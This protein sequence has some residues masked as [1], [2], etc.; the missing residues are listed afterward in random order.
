ME[1]SSVITGPVSH[2]HSVDVQQILAELDVV[3]AQGLSTQ[4]AE[5]RLRLFGPNIL[6]E[7]NAV[8]P[9]TILLRQF[10]SVMLLILFV[11]AV[12]SWFLG[13]PFDATVIVILILVNIAI[14][15][16]QEYTAE[17]AISSLKKLVETKCK[18][19]RD[20]Q[21]TL[22]KPSELVP[23]DI[24]LL[25]GGDKVSAD[26]RLVV[27][28]NLQT[29]E[30][31]LTGESSAV[32]KEV[33]PVEESALIPDR[34]NMVYMG[35]LVASGTAEAV[36]VATGS[37]TQL[38]QIAE[39]IDEIHQGDNHYDQITK[40]LT[41]VMGVVAV[42]SAI[43]TFIIGYWVRQFELYE[44]VTFT[45][46][47][48][49]SALP[50][51]LP[52]ILVVVLTIGAQRMAKRHA[53]VRKLSAIETLGV[54]SVIMTDKTGTLTL[55]EMRATTIQFLER[56]PVKLD[57]LEFEAVDHQTKHALQIAGTC[58]TVRRGKTGDLIGDPTEVALYKLAAES[59]LFE[60][61][62]CL[63]RKMDD[64]PFV[65]DLRLRACLVEGV[66]DGQRHLF[67]VGAP[68]S[69]L[70]HSLEAC[71]ANGDKQLDHSHKKK[72]LAQV[73]EMT[74]QGQR[75]LA[76]AYKPVATS[77]TTVAT[78]DIRDL[79][80]VGIVG[81]IDPARPEI[82]QAISVA[83]QAGIRVVMT[84][85]DHPLTAVAIAKEVGLMSEDADEVLT[86][87]DVLTMSDLQLLKALETVVVFAR[88]SPNTKLRI[89]QLFQ[90][91]DHIVAMTGD[92]VN[93]A[94]AL[95]KADVGI[96]MGK[97]GTDVA[98][99]ASDI[100]LANDNFASIIDA[101][102]EGRTQFSNVRRTSSFLIIT[103]VAES[104]SLLV[105]LLIGFPLPLLPLQILWLNIITGGVTDFALATEQSHENMM[106]VAPR[107]PK[108][109]IITATLLPL[110]L[111]IVVA[112]VVLVVGVFAYYLP[113]GLE[114]ART[115]AFAV[116]SLSL[117][118]NMFNLRA[119]HHSVIK[120][121]IFTNPTVN[122]TFIISFV[123]M[124]VVL[125]VPHLQ[126]V[127]GFVSLSA[128]ELGSI[129]AASLVLFI[130]AEAVKVFF[131]AGTKYRVV[132]Q[133]S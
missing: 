24:I 22:L 91:R 63:P 61:K 105:T 20:M 114:K 34:K 74:K 58:Q 84:T 87:S 66:E 95:R 15:F 29:I 23:G 85:G 92:G 104:L 43:I 3:V 60:K 54:V 70:E 130:V 121:G 82:K 21:I 39:R 50:E 128:F 93:D 112:M 81:M 65:Q 106:K 83:Q 5:D 64:L 31:P 133:A 38:G 96:A 57:K 75:V 49:V 9:L 33:E 42:V 88:L 4:E 48:L 51:S 46:A 115:A 131:P 123:L 47:T 6:K 107:D 7:K 1:K 52:I 18:V 2:P 71:T 109:K 16:Y 26:A 103:N 40:S 126:D 78:E 110:F 62:D 79:K 27:T 17:Q 94:P 77:V 32:E 19:R 98:R 73:E 119:L 117:L 56:E 76:L 13:H 108:E 44:M 111:T 30:S 36:V 125:Y 68:E 118:L 113:E 90:K 8:R 122:I 101:I 72:L 14:G 99:E 41:T 35:T 69:V 12:L 10:K 120:I 11:A 116:L 59:G 124:L 28:H 89:A 45:I 132:P 86:E 80:Y 25:E 129:I 37:I 127:F 97:V 67:V 55:N 102:R 53:I 100:V